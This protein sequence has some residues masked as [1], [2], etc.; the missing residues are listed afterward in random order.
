[1][2]TFFHGREA[3]LS[4]CPGFEEGRSKYLAR[5][6]LSHYLF[7]LKAL[8]SG[9]GATYLG[10]VRALLNEFGYRRFPWSLAVSKVQ[11]R[12]LSRTTSR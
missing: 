12:F 5:Y 6:V 4:S 2:F 7:G 11:Q 9:Y 8:L 1:M 10:E 3:E